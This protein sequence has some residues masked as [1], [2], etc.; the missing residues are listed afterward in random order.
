MRWF[1]D[2]CFYMLFAHSLCWLC[3]K[4]GAQPRSLSVSSSLFSW[5]FLL[6]F[7]ALEVSYEG[8]AARGTILTIRGVRARGAVQ[9]YQS[10]VRDPLVSMAA[11]LSLYL[12]P[13]EPQ[14]N[15]HST[16]S[17]LK[18]RP[19]VMFEI[20]GSYFSLG[21]RTTWKWYCRASN[22]TR[23]LWRSAFSLVKWLIYVEEVTK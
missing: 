16:E 8:V 14:R 17:F 11:G 2:M 7:S 9:N 22:R 1:I 21:R 3:N 20:Y 13:D 10:K 5:W 19:W 23:R 4:D 18:L 12:Y 6:C 15:R